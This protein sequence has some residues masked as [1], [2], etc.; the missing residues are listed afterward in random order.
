MLAVE[1]SSLQSP[2]TLLGL[3]SASLKTS[4]RSLASLSLSFL[5]LKGGS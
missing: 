4:G 2:Q 5:P 3:A 1:E